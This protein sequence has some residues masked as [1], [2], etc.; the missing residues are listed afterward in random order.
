MSSIDD[1][2]SEPECTGMRGGAVPE[3]HV[4]PAQDLANQSWLL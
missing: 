4:A 3:R 1:S 2:G